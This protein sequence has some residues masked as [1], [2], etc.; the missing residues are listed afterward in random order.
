M[1]QKRWKSEEKVTIALA[2][3]RGAEGVSQL[4]KRYGVT[5]VTIHR[6]KNEFVAA[7]RVALS[8]ERTHGNGRA[9]E[10]ARENEELRH[11]VA[12]LTVANRLLKK[13]AGVLS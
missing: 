2:A 8:G 3:L 6:W 11:V 12:E 4:A 7:G 5:E 13:S 1:G 10:L 9:T